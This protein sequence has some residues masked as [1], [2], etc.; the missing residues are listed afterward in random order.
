MED[1]QINELLEDTR[2]RILDFIHKGKEFSNGTEFEEA[3]FI[4]FQNVLKEKSLPTSH[5]G[6][7]GP[8]TFPDV[9]YKDFGI[10]IKMTKKDG[11]TV[12]G[13]SIRESTKVSNIA[14]IF[15]FFLK[16]GGTPDIRYGKYK[17]Y[18]ADVI[19]THS[20][21]YFID[22]SINPDQT[23]FNKAGLEYESFTGRDAINKIKR[24]YAQEGK[25]LWWVD[26]SSTDKDK[27][28]RAYYRD[29]SELN[30]EEKEKFMTEVMILFPEIFTT[31]KDKFKRVGAYLIENYECINPHV[32]DTFTAGGKK[33]IDSE[34]Y[35][36]IIGHLYEHANQIRRRINEF[37][38]EILEDY[39]GER[40]QDSREEIW[41]SKISENYGDE[42]IKEIY[43][44][45][46][47][48]Q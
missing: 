6:H 8:Q 17:D 25:D 32:R 14:N 21:R 22:M 13:N 38:L 15:I 43:R 36:K 24:F 42:S 30:N 48:S 39:W 4:T 41:L 47:S 40:I 44:L 11:W 10:E 5:L 20:P 19:V 7:S 18:M 28:T 1:A 31:K 35:P 2:I 46:L 29:Y 37:D 9:V 27:E 26:S 33:I 23:I 16:Q 12:P 34:E 45:A 3:F